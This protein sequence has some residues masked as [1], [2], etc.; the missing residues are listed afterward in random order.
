MYRLS[1]LQAPC[2][3]RLILSEDEVAEESLL[4]ILQDFTKS[5][6]AQCSGQALQIGLTGCLELPLSS[7]SFKLPVNI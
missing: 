3:L 5:H 4:R 1:G 6:H 7:K 2:F